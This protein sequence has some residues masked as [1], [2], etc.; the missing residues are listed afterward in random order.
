MP[1]IFNE[2][3]AL[4]AMLAGITVSDAK[5]NSRPVGVWFGQPD[6]EIRE[7]SYPYM[8][9]DLVDVNEAIER[10]HR[11]VIDLNY[12]PEGLNPDV[13]YTVDFPIPMD[14]YYQITTYSRNPHHDR[15]L[16]SALMQDKL[17]LRFNFLTVPEDGTSRRV[18][19]LGFS[20][21]DTVESDKRLFVN[22]FSVRVSSEIIYGLP[23]DIPAVDEVITTYTIIDETFDTQPGN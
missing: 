10:S 14:L 22:T 21:R 1:F 23:K 15:Q 12:T 6:L 17:P 5:N 9:I 16:I 4:K 2:D 8:T 20:K 11:G 18:D 3:K 19:F 7:Q 13:T